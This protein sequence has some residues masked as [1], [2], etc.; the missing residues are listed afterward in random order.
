MGRL[1]MAG[2]IWKSVISH[3]IVI[4]VQGFDG[5]LRF[6]AY[7]N[8]MIHKDD[9]SSRPASANPLRRASVSKA[10]GIPETP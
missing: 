9:G 10:M 1:E 2:R 3:K 8:C 6:D 4:V 5:A 7:N